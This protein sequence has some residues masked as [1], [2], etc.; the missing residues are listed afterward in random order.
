MAGRQTKLPRTG[1][2]SRTGR[3]KRAKNDKIFAAVDLGTNNCRLLIVKPAGQHFQV[4]DSFS[5]IVRLGAGLETHGRLSDAAMDRAVAALKICASKIN[6]H[7]NVKVKCVA[8]QACREADNGAGFIERVSH[9]TNLRLEVIGGRD[10]AEL[11]AIGCGALFD[12]KRPNAIVFDIGGGSTE[13]TRLKLSHGRFELKD[14]ISAPLGVVRLAERYNS[15]NLTAENY[16]QMVVACRK[17]LQHFLDRQGDITS[18]KSLQILG[19][20]GTVTTLAAIQLGLPVYD[21]NKVDGCTLSKAA[22]LDVIQRL[23]RMNHADLVAHP[24]IGAERADLV[25][26]GCAVLEAV[27]DCWPVPVIKVADRGVRDGL[28]LRMIR[29]DQR[30]HRPPHARRTNSH[31]RT[32][33]SH[34]TSQ[35]GER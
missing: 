29:K 17:A 26:A 8:T 24:C 20:S 25:L 31:R 22:I 13:L 11:A 6:R 18:L 16:T 21:R 35:V 9:E 1:R 14:T 27:L 10:E 5:R 7:K 34:Q 4:V 33:S 23:L 19:T 15:K 3:T 12:R 28:L 2:A 32:S 30:R